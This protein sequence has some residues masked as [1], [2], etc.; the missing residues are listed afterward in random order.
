MSFSFLYNA[1][2]ENY[3]VQN[4]PRGGGGGAGGLWPAQ[5]LV[6]ANFRFSYQIK[7]S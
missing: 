1:V 7:L 3:N 4:S 6:G 2:L 5:G